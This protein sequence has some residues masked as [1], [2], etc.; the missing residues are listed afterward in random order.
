[1][2]DVLISKFGLPALGLAA[3]IEGEASA[4]LGGVLAH[5]ALFP[6]SSAIMA[7]A[8][9]SFIVDQI[10]FL[11]AAFPSDRHGCAQSLKAPRRTRSSG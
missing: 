2:I 5:K 9:G 3:G 11:W 1:V 10:L 8:I 7:V 4:I 6:L